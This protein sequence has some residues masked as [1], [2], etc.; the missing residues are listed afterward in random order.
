MSNLILFGVGLLVGYA[1]CA[2]TTK[3]QTPPTPP[4]K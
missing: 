3:N 1:Y 2:Y 4:T